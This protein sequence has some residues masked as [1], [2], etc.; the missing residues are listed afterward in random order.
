MRNADFARVPFIIAAK[1]AT[2]GGARP[3]CCK[4]LLAD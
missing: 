3:G 2:W 1:V 4:K